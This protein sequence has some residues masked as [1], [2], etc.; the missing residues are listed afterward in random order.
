MKNNYIPLRVNRDF[1][2][3]ISTYFDFFKQNIKNF[4]NV[5]ISYNG[6]FLVG[7]LIA[8]YLLVSGFIGMIAHEYNYE[9][10]SGDVGLEQNYYYF[11]VLCHF[12]LCCCSKL[13]VIE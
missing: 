13:F 5:F 6:V 12:Y 7:L 11:S 3:I 1:G 10:V 2:E 9:N 4:T 8:S